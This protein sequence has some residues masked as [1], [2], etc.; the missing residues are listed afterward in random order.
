MNTEKPTSLLKSLF[1]NLKNNFSLVI[2]F[3][4]AVGLINIDYFYLTNYHLD[5]LPYISPTEIIGLAFLSLGKFSL[6]YIVTK[7]ILVFFFLGFVLDPISQR[8]RHAIIDINI[9]EDKIAILP[10]LGSFPF[11][12]AIIDF[13]LAIGTSENKPLEWTILKT[14]I[15]LPIS[16]II[17]VI[18]IVLLAIG[19]VRNSGWID[20]RLMRSYKLSNVLTIYIIVQ[21]IA[22]IAEQVK[23]EGRDA[24]FN[25]K[26]AGTTII[27]AGDTIISDHSRSYI[28][29]TTTAV[30]VC[31]FSSGEIT[32][33]PA[34]EVKKLIIRVKEIKE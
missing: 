31:D 19:T 10:V 20:L 32:I 25:G 9:K 3:F 30:F 27:T 5:I 4:L 14:T 34:S 12:L 21:T 15:I 22:T 17:S 18:V 8:L 7:C 11:L 26:Y 6:G 2:A 24:R 23:K 29:R 28:G 16:T 33:L 13:L 1:L